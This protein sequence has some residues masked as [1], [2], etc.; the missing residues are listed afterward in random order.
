V[1]D[2]P[3]VRPVSLN[4]LF[5][6]GQAVV[7]ENCDIDLEAGVEPSRCDAQVL[8]VL[9]DRLIVNPTDGEIGRR[10]LPEGAKVR[11]HVSRFGVWHCFDASVSRTSSS[12]TRA[13]ELVAVTGLRESDR[14]NGARVGLSMRPESLAIEGDQAKPA[15]ALA[16]VVDD[17]SSG[18]IGISCLQEIPLGSKLQLALALPRMF[19]CIQACGE[20]V[21]IDGPV[22]D[23]TGRWRWR[24]GVVFSDISQND[25][26]RV[27]AFVLFEQH[28]R[29]MKAG[30]P[31]E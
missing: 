2:T 16:P 14:R 17:V 15:P 20:V 22:R 21:R 3:D 5:F 6:P 4:K 7:L 30:L 29:R 23:L 12:S 25:R 11:G 10:A 18:G 1:E 27:A 26:N 8:A 13:V 28:R 24:M 19:G 9:R 31:M